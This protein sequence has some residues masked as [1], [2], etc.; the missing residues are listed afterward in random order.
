MK[1]RNYL[2]RGR[3]LTEQQRYPKGG[4]RPEEYKGHSLMPEWHP[5]DGLQEA[6]GVEQVGHAG[7]ASG[8]PAQLLVSRHHQGFSPQYWA[9]HSLLKLWCFSE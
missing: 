5:V 7:G 4:G 2:R 1:G 6:P 3:E 9:L 8:G